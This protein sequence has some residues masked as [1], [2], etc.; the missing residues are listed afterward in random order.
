MTDIHVGRRHDR[1]DADFLVITAEALQFHPEK[2]D[3]FGGSFLNMVEGD[4]LIVDQIPTTS[5][6]FGLDHADAFMP[7]I[8]ADMDHV[9]G[10]SLFLENLSNIVPGS[11]S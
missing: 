4:L 11:R 1:P 9:P 5:D 10:G 8:D 2:I 7:D 6:L 3:E